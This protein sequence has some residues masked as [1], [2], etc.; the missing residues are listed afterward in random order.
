MTT[1]ASLDDLRV[2]NVVKTSL[3]FRSAL[4]YKQLTG[5]IFALGRNPSNSGRRW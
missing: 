5:A 2:I 4:T 1:E 3:M